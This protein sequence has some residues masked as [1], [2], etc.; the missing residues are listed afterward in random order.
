M[1]KSTLGGGA[2]YAGH[3]DQSA[4]HD[5][6]PDWRPRPAEN[7]ERVPVAESRP[8]PRPRARHAREDQS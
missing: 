2:T 8:S 6:V 1:A 5:V 3:E 7:V 4:P